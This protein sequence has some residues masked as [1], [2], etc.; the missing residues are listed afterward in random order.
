MD[1]GELVIAI[2]TDVSQ[3]AFLAIFESVIGRDDIVLFGIEVRVTPEAELSAQ[4]CACVRL[5]HENIDSAYSE[6]PLH[7]QQKLQLL[8]KNPIV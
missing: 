5:S 3:R 7:S 2:A 4:R 6:L 8:L 1:L